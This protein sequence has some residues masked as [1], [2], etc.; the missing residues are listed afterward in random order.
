MAADG[1]LRTTCLRYAGW[2]AKIA[3]GNNLYFFTSPHRLSTDCIIF[4]HA[5][6][7]PDDPKYGGVFTVPDGVT[8]TFYTIH[9]Q[10]NLSNPAA[11]FDKPNNVASFV[12]P[13]AETQVMTFWN[14]K[15]KRS[16]QRSVPK[17]NAEGF[18]TFKSENIGFNRKA[19]QKLLGMNVAADGTL[20]ADEASLER[21]HFRGG[22][23]CYNYLMMKALGEHFAKKPGGAYWGYEDIEERQADADQRRRSGD[24]QAWAP[25]YVSVRNRRWAWMSNYVLLADAVRRVREGARAQGIQ[26]DNFYLGGCRGIHPGWR[27]N[28]GS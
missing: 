17:T 7:V 23:R 1:L 9:G 10:S 16:E 18:H 13:R 4:A 5:G 15:L 3:F 2:V 14:A 8:L 19:A 6:Y 20:S 27:P 22:D 24:P 26:L 28:Q 21:K 25:H 11:V 12:A